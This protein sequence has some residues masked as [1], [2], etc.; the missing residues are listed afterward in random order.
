MANITQEE[1]QQ[2]QQIKQKF[3]SVIEE[4]GRIEF[5]KISLEERTAAAKSYLK[6]V[7][8]EEKQALAV[9]TE[10]YGEVQLDLE[11]GEITE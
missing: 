1:L 9:L 8:E 3:G 7:S 5:Q 4:L 10:K 11:T 2:L 6:E